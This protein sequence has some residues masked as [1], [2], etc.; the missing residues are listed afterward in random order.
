VTIRHDENPAE[1]TAPVV[2]RFA[3]AYIARVTESI[4]VE[5]TGRVA[6]VTLNRPEKLNALDGAMVTSLR[7]ELGRIAEDD[8]VRCVVLTGAGRGFC[9][10][11]DVEALARRGG[12]DDTSPGRMPSPD[13]RTLVEVG[14]LLYRMPKVTIAR[15]NGPCAGA[16][17]SFACACD[18]RYAA[19]SAV[20]T[21]AFLRVGTSGDHGSAWFLSRAVGPAA[22]RQLLFLSERIGAE[23]A[24]RIGLV[25][26]VVADDELG[27][28]VDAIAAT[29]SVAA[30]TALVNMKQNLVDASELPLSEYLDRETERFLETDA[31]GESRAAARSFFERR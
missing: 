28:R 16:G 10:G 26:D 15:I 11:G 13:M 27:P 1:V 21:T 22:A 18:L 7:D 8:T 25:H 4:V 23:E 14:E 19:R 9:A 20:F 17:L 12:A 2:G 31:S 6:V 29:L 3:L 24:V 5:R 30:H